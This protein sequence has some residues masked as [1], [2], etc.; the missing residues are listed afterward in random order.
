VEEPVRN[1]Y[2]RALLMAFIWMCVVIGLVV[3]YLTGNLHL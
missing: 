3:L 1:R 2:N